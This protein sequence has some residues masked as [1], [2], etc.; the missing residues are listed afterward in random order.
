MNL[1]PD[2]PSLSSK[3]LY[4]AYR[5]LLRP[6]KLNGPGARLLP[7]RELCVKIWKRG[8]VNCGMLG[9]KTQVSGATRHAPDGFRNQVDMTSDAISYA[10][11]N[12]RASLAELAFSCLQNFILSRGIAEDLRR[13]NSCREILK[14]STSFCFLDLLHFVSYI[15]RESNL[16]TQVFFWLNSSSTTLS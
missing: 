15:C 5:W 3:D 1:V 14:A 10:R 4:S 13:E 9:S 6:L 7:P 2:T 8:F 12:Y 11:R 16:C